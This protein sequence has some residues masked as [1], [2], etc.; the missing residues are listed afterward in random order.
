VNAPEQLP[1]SRTTVVA[2][3]PAPPMVRPHTPVG[4]TGTPMPVTPAGSTRGRSSR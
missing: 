1:V 4:V 2:R 3:T